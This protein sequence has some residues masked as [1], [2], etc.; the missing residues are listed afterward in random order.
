MNEE[1]KR[2]NYD[3]TSTQRAA[4]R[5]AHLHQV[6]Q[7]NGY[8]TWYKLETAVINGAVLTVEAPGD[9]DVPVYSQDDAIYQR[10]TGAI[11]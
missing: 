11:K 5:A 4:R 6:A 8:D 3:Y 2:R 7:A 9:V 10:L 1:G